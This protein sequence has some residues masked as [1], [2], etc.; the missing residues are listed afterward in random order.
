MYSL[1]W[2]W[3]MYPA[4]ALVYLLTFR[5]AKDELRDWRLEWQHLDHID[6]ASSG[7]TCIEAFATHFDLRIMGGWFNVADAALLFF[8]VILAPFLWLACPDVPPHGTFSPSPDGGDGFFFDP[9]S[10][11]WRDSFQRSVW[12]LLLTSLG[13]LALTFR[14]LKEA[15]WHRGVSAVVNTLAYAGVPSASGSRT[16]SRTSAPVSWLFSVRRPSRR[17]V[18]SSIVMCRRS[19]PC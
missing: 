7:P 8:L 9:L 4:I 5:F 18:P 14:M 19:S 11:F 13:I 6:G 2:P 15:R 12:V 16:I 1:S 10:N 17:T 3:A